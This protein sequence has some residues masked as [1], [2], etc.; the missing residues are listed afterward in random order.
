MTT[1]ENAQLRRKHY[2]ATITRL[3]KAHEDLM[4]MRV[5]PD[6]LLPKHLPGQY[7]TLG[8]GNWEP[9]HPGA[10]EETP[11]P[12]EGPKLI[13]RAYSISCSILDDDGRLLDRDG[14]NWLEF[15]IV[16]VREAEKAPPALTPRIFL[17][18][19]GD[20][21]FLGEK[22]TGHFTL[23]GV[24]PD[25]SILFL[26]TGTG[27]AP[28]N[29]MLWQLLGQRHPGKILSACCVRYKRDLGYLGIHEELMRRHPNYTYLA[30]TTREAM[31][32]G[33][34]VYIQD[35]LTSGQME[36]RLGAPLD[37]DRTHVYLCGNPKMIGVP[38]V[39][40]PSGRTVYPQPPGVVEIL[41]KRG[42]RRDQ[43]AL[44]VRG[45]VH[46]EEYW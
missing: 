35:L 11:K 23:E 6:Y 20:R 36:E 42:F 30:L 24:K 27:E 1:E 45:N 40:R 39:D 17:L 7:S 46:F 38:E 37:P 13:R 5:T 8:L 4:V 34:K 26:S 9:R 3:A 15:Y 32:V 44:K 33:H 22:I 2:N 19:E 28:H 25:D 29:Y 31:N 21:I 43:P 18:N 41:E 16:L 14:A 10:Q 12:G